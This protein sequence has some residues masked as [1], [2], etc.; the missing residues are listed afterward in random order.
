MKLRIKDQSIRFRLS[1]NEVQKLDTEGEIVAS[2]CIGESALTYV[3]NRALEQ[4]FSCNF[5][6]GKI[7]VRV[8]ID[9]LQT[10]CNSDQVSIECN[11]PKSGQIPS[12][13]LLIE[14]DFQCLI[15]RAG[16]DESGLFPNPQAQPQ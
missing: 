5:L 7:S 4:T 2:T 14:K 3:I 15:E 6:E 16:E 10:W 8:P 11:L 13:Q 9:I 1:Q 12:L